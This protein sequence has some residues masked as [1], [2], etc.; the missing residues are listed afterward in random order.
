MAMV[1]MYEAPCG[2]CR[3]DISRAVV[4]HQVAVPLLAKQCGATTGGKRLGSSR[5]TKPA[6]II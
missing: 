1:D 4:S 6:T 2:E 3:A 5:H